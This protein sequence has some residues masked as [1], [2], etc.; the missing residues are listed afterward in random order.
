MLTQLITVLT[1][2]YTFLAIIIPNIKNEI[3]D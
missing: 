1:W 3:L 2:V